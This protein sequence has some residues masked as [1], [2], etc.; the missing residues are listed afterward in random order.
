[1]LRSVSLKNPQVLYGYK[2]YFS[3]FRPRRKRAL[4]CYLVQPLVDSQ[5]GEEI[6]RF[7]NSGL[8]MSWARVLNELGYIVDIINWDDI[9]FKPERSYDLVVFHGG[10]NF[11]KISNTLTTKTRIIHYSTGSYWK[12]NNRNEDK[13]IFNLERR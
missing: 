7:S 11:K 6:V 10:K 4:L 1:M 12:F 9:D 3:R 13:R 5:R 2:R 8:S